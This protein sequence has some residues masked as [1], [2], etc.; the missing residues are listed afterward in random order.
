[1]TKNTKDHIKIAV[2]D[3]GFDITHPSL[4]H[5]IVDPFNAST[6]AGGNVSPSYKEWHGTAVAGVA[7][8]STIQG[9]VVGV[10]T[11]DK[12]TSGV[13][14]CVWRAPLFP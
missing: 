5:K 6:G 7:A 3:D 2:I 1:M 11:N 13:M 12:G 9:E 4:S 14:R 10:A 8:A